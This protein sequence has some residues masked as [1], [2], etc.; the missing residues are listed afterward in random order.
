MANGISQIVWSPLAQGVLTGKYRP[1]QPPPAGSRATSE[2][3]AIAIGLVM[4]DAVL[5]AV[6]R[7]QPIADGKGWRHAPLTREAVGERLESTSWAT[8]MSMCWSWVRDRQ[9]CS[10]GSSSRGTASAH[11]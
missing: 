1:G 7:L 4:K 10:P 8:V 2:T 9:D 11:V 3:M 5:E 6:E